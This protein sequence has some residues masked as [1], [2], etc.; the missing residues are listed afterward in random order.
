VKSL[1]SLAGTAEKMNGTTITV[2]STFRGRLPAHQELC[3]YRVA[4]EALR[5]AMEHGQAK[6]VELSLQ[7]EGTW[8]VLSI[9]DDGKGFDKAADWLKQSGKKNR[10]LGLVGMKERVGEFG[11]A[12]HVDSAPGQGTRVAA[13]VPML[14]RDPDLGAEDS[15][16]N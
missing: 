5:N 3:L 9:S 8:V 6:H 16:A 1:E 14:V 7:Q 11:G 15:N 10:G 4:Q 12:F 13:R 2:T